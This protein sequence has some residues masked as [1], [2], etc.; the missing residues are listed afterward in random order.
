MRGRQQGTMII[1]FF[2]PHPSQALHLVLNDEAEGRKS[3]ILEHPPPPL[4]GVAL[5]GCGHTQRAWTVCERPGG[6]CMS[7]GSAMFGGLAVPWAHSCKSGRGRRHETRLARS[8]V[9]KRVVD[10]AGWRGSGQWA[11][12]SRTDVSACGHSSLGPWQRGPMPPPVTSGAA[13]WGLAVKG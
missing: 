5:S 2:E 10:R 1:F 7:S 4:F 3:N 11:W 13:P 12:R 6:G 8:R 9:W